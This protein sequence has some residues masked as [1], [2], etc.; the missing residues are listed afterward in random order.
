MWSTIAGLVMQRLAARLGTVTGL[1]LAQVC[2][3]AYPTIPRIFLWIIVEFSIIVSDMQGVIGA[4]FAIY[5]LSYKMLVPCVSYF[6]ESIFV[7]TNMFSIIK[8]IIE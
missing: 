2:Y 7:I 5:I 4:S 8:K 3:R 6:H 1:D